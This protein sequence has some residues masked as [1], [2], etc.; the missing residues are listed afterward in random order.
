MSPT[1]FVTDE[2]NGTLFALPTEGEVHKRTRG[3]PKKSL[4]YEAEV[5]HRRRAV[6]ELAGY[7]TPASVERERILSA[8]RGV[9][10][11]RPGNPKVRKP[12]SVPRPGDGT[13]A[14]KA[15]EPGSSVRVLVIDAYHREPSI[16]VDACVMFP[17]PHGDDYVW[18]SFWD[19]QAPVA[20]RLNRTRGAAEY[21]AP[22][23]RVVELRARFQG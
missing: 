19:G 5:L 1:E 11:V 12:Y 10:P 7:F 8:A 22:T 4:V 14:P 18:V 15:G 2:I 23:S 13:F 17:A 9:K 16:E 21:R 20:V 3:R 6:R